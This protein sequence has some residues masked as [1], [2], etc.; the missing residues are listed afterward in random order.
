MLS[1]S[2]NLVLL[3]EVLGGFSSTGHY[4]FFYFLVFLV[5]MSDQT[6]NN[7]TDR[8]KKKCGHKNN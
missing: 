8:C 1:R 4:F 2:A 6:I 7:F 3:L 5:L